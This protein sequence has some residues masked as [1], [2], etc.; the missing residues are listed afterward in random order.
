MANLFDSRLTRALPP[1][2]PP[3]LKHDYNGNA[4]FSHWPSEVW[5]RDNTA[6][7]RSQLRLIQCDNPMIPQDLILFVLNS[8]DP[9][10]HPD[11]AN[12]FFNGLD[13]IVGNLQDRL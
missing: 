10:T 5:S 9:H 3:N 7:K 13:L 2:A 1:Q 12:N 6:K 4:D 11:R 8:L